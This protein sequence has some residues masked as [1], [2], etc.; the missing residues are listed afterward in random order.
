MIDTLQNICIGLLFA[1]VLTRIP[2]IKHTYLTPEEF[3]KMM[4]EIANDDND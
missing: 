1:I 4:K 3:V 2:R